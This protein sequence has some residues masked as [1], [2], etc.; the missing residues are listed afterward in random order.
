LEVILMDL[1]RIQPAA[2][3]QNLLRC[4]AVT[5]RYGLRLTEADSMALAETQS[6]VLKASGRIAF[7]GGAAEE[8]AVAFCDSPYVQQDSYVET[9][10]ELIDAFYNF[11]NEAMDEIDDAEAIALMKRLFDGEYCEG[12]MDRLREELLPEAARRIRAG[13]PPEP[14]VNGGGPEDDYDE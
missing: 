11:K 2:M 3:A 13:L 1:I 14:E 8:L 10:S 5:A 4:N 6:R 7:T 12:S 9:L